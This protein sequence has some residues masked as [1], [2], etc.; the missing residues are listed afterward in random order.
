M[1]TEAGE[2]YRQRIFAAVDWIETNLSNPLSLQQAAESSAWSFFHFHRIFTA[3]VG[4]P[5][6][7]FLRMRRLS[8]A[9][10]LLSATARSVADIAAVCGFGSVEAFHRSFKSEFS[11]T[12]AVYRRKTSALA[13]MNP[14]APQKHPMAHQAACL[15][16]RPEVVELPARHLVCAA[17]NF[18]LEDPLLGQRINAFWAELSGTWPLEKISPTGPHFG[19]A[20]SLCGHE[21]SHIRYLAGC[22]VAEPGTVTETGQYQTQQSSSSKSNVFFPYTIPP[23]TYLQALHRG[24]ASRL[25]QT[26]LYLYASWLPRHGLIPSVCMDFDEYGPAY[27]AEN[28]ESPESEVIF[29][30]P[31][32]PA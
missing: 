22:L 26:Y 13:V 2:E 8:E 21:G 15:V 32:K 3:V 12:P 24:P 10:R 14:F 17:R 30:I 9:S 27:R 6:G 5:P 1:R 19:L 7:E 20:E 23:G 28:P 29:R 18:E 11:V 31:V 25:N 16:G 4:V